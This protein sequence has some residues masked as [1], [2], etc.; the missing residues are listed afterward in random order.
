MLSKEHVI[1]AIKSGKTAS[2][3]DNR[4]FSRLVDFFEPEYYPLFGFKIMEGCDPASVLVRP[5]TEEEVKQQLAHDLDFGFEK[6]LDKRSIS[7]NLMYNV[8]KM[9]MWVLEDVLQDL[10]DYKFYGLPLFKAVAEK[11]DLP[12][13][14]GDKE[15]DDPEFDG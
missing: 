6:A 12:D 8:V 3:F 1:E 5:W 15:P 9:W 10:E 13:P 2:C 14:T 7:S 4:D 11:Y